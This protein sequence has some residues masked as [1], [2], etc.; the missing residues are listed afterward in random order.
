L[1]GL[2]RRTVMIRCLG[3]CIILG[4]CLVALAPAGEF[5]KK[6]SIGDAAPSWT[7]L[8]GIDGKKHSLADWKDKK[9]VVL[10]FTCNSCPIARSYEE[11]IIA[12]AKKYAGPNDPVA[13]VAM[14]VNTVEADRLPKMEERAKE[15][16]FNFPYLYDE[17]QKAALDYGATYTPEFFVLDKDR[18]IAYMGAM[19]DESPPAEAK[20][21]FLEDAV[22]AVLKGAKSPKGETLARGCAIRF[23]RP[24]R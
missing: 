5:N 1:I 10:V 14:N 9:A 7:D 21:R 2:A 19:D 22:G 11:R 13:V 24:R 15:I 16:G 20:A 23:T 3:S 6:L 17:T 18:K 8:P 4:C 12:F